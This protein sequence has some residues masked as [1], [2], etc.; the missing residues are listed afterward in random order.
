MKTLKRLNLK[1]FGL[2]FISNNA[3][4]LLIQIFVLPL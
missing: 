3:Q 4:Y 2:F 1:K